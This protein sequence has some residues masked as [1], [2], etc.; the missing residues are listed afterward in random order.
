MSRTFEGWI[1]L[2]KCSIRGISEENAK[3]VARLCYETDQSGGK[4]A[5]WHASSLVHGNAVCPCY[6]CYGQAP[7]G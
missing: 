2:A 3:A 5:V 7:I 4:A 1:Y 6:D